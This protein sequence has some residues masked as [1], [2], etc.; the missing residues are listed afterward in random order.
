MTPRL[1]NPTVM[2]VLASTCGR[3]G[4]LL[5]QG[6]LRSSCMYGIASLNYPRTL[7]SKR[8]VSTQI[9]SNDT[10]PA[11]TALPLRPA[12]R[13]Q[14]T[15]RFRTRNI[16]YATV[17]LLGGYVF[18][19]VVRF[20]VVP[21]PLPVPGSQEDALYT[22]ALHRD[23]DELS[24]VKELRS[25]S[26]EWQE[27][28]AYDDKSMLQ[29]QSSFTAGAM[30]GSR[31]LGVQKIFWN[32]KEQRSIGVAFFGGSLSGWPGVTHGGAIATIMQEHMERLIAGEKGDF[33]SADGLAMDM[34][35]TYRKPTLANRFHVIRAEIDESATIDDTDLPVITKATLEDID[36][37]AILAEASARCA[38]PS[39]VSSASAQTAQ[40]QPIAPVSSW[41]LSILGKY[42]G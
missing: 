27:M 6:S 23:V 3:P 25:Y 39:Q 29:R 19:Q 12:E 33:S 14:R 15:H 34:K 7:N 10:K 31:G 26:N 41:S 11:S 28:E 42:F 4:A 36:S 30:G 18:G 32:E 5:P 37:G 40:T 16:F 24:I 17:F 20:A 9:P 13:Y 21:P 2:Q 8:T 35:I 38:R 1:G 22:A